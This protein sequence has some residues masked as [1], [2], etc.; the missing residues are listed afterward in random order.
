MSDNAKDPS[1]GHVLENG[2]SEAT[3]LA[4][5]IFSRP[6]GFRVDSIK[7]VWEK[8]EDGPEQDTKLDWRNGIK[9]GPWKFGESRA[10]VWDMGH[11]VAWY[12]VVDELK[13]VDGSVS[14]FS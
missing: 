10:D 14:S 12:K 8:A 9:V 5:D 1:E 13:K 2:E 6:S 3:E 7:A 11:I 4:K